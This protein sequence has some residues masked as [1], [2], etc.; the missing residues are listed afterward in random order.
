MVVAGTNGACFNKEQPWE[1]RGDL[2]RFALQST[3]L[4]NRQDTDPIEG[5]QKDDDAIN[6]QGILCVPSV[7][8]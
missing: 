5:R 4:A 7:R 3:L 1:S 2:G 6:E 8:P